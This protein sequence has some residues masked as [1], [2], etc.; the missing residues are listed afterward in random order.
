MFK[1]RL[2]YAVD[3]IALMMEAGASFRESLATIVRENRGHALGEEF[4]QVLSEIEY[5]QTLRQALSNLRDRLADNELNEM[6][7]A[8]HKAEELGTPLSMIFLRQAEQMRLMRSQWAE[9]MAGKANANISFPGLIVM[10]GCMLI[11]IGPFVLNALSVSSNFW[12]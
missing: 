2:P 12:E 7:F 8:V 9:R 10:L 5:G 3:L 6:I 4:G 11:V 1:R